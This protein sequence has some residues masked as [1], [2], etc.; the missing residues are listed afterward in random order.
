LNIRTE[1]LDNHAVRLTVEVDTATFEEAKRQ[2]VRSISGKVNIPGF[3][4]G[5][6]PAAIITRYVGEAY[7]LEEAIESLGQKLYREALE[8][9]AIEPAAPGSMDDFSPEPPTFI[10]TVPLAPK[11]TLSS[12]YRDIRIEYVEQ[13]VG[14]AEVEAEL[15]SLQREFAEKVASEEG[16]ELQDRLTCD[17]HSFF[18]EVDAETDVE[19]DVHDRKEEAYV[20]RHGAVINLLEGE[21]EPLAPGFTANMLGVK[22]GETRNFRI[23]L[24]T[25]EPTINPDIAGKTIEFVV[26][27]EQV[28]KVVLPEIDEA[29]A[30][31]ISQHYNWDEAFDDIVN[32][33]EDDIE[34]AELETALDEVEAELEA[35]EAAESEDIE[36]ELEAVPDVRP[37]TLEEVRAKLKESLTKRTETKARETYSNKVLEQII[38]SAEVAFNDASVEA[39]IDDMV[40]DL[41]ERL[42]QNRLDLD[43]YL[44]QTGR[45][46]EDIRGDYREPAAKFLRRSLAVREFAR[47]EKLEVTQVELQTRFM[48]I[49]GEIGQDAI[50]QLGILRDERFVNNMANNMMSQKIE[51]R[52]IA[53][54]KGEAP[55]LNAAPV[56]EIAE[57]APT[58]EE[59]SVVEDAPAAEETPAADA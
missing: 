45:T 41:K 21:D 5:K 53:I 11:V 35:A 27:V 37:L 24:P 16:A 3:R 31:K 49:L 34:D 42:R 52:A 43:T 18:V 20:H 26:G 54:G 48:E 12:D 15:R 13:T 7:I 6:A 36:S 4:K 58:T 59:T 51:D 22:A 46:I 19:A 50:N 56:L 17:L 32:D 23:T 39:E 8:Q 14:D 38:E 47:A 10:Y 44:R 57:E 30:A 25:D 55:D 29:L 33:D 9:S 40:E 1:Q 2:A 28:E